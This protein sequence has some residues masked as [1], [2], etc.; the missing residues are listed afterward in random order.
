MGSRG[1]VQAVRLLSAAGG[2]LALGHGSDALKLS[3]G[4]NDPALWLAG[5]RNLILNANDSQSI[6]KRVWCEDDVVVLTMLRRI[7][8]LW[9]G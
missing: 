4:F 5:G 9:G 3:A 6:L 7:T 2:L 8:N 1:E